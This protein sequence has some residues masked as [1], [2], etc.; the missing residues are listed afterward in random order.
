MSRM[1]LS[2]LLTVSFFLP[3]AYASNFQATVVEV[4]DGDSLQVRFVGKVQKVQLAGIDCPERDQPFGQEAAEFTS[5]LVLGKE[6]TVEVLRINSNG[7]TFG[8]VILS[9]GQSLNRELVRAGLAWW[10]EARSKDPAL[11]DLEQE[12]RI[13]GVGLWSEADPVPPWEH[14]KLRRVNP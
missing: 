14:R 9:D 11:G 7:S 4:S 10:K 13:N 3:W 12:A 1:I 5:E 2:C 8:D 6:V